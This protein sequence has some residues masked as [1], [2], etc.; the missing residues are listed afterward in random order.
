VIGKRLSKLTATCNQALSVAA[1]IGR[2]F[3][4]ETLR[5]LTDIDEDV[6]LEALE[7]AQRVRVVDDASIAGEVRFR[8]NHALFRQTLYEELFTPR[9]LRLHQRVARVLEAQYSAHLEDHAAVLSEHFAQSSDSADLDKARHYAELAAAAATRISAHGEAARHL[10]SALHLLGLLDN[11]TTQQRC[12]LLLRLGESMVA[13]GE[14]QSTVDEVA[15]EAFRL[16]EAL[17]DTA[18]A[19]SACTIGLRG[20]SSQRGFSIVDTPDFRR[21]TERPDRYAQP[22]SLE[23]VTADLARVASLWSDGQE[24]AAHEIPVR[25]VQ[26]AWRIGQVR[27][28]STLLVDVWMVSPHRQQE[29]LDLANELSPTVDESNPATRS[30]VARLHMG[31]VFL[32][33]CDR[34]KCQA[35]WG[36]LPEQVEQTR[37]PFVR[38]TDCRARLITECLDGRPASALELG[39]RI[40]N[41]NEAFGLGLF[42]QATAGMYVWR[43][44]LHLGSFDQAV[45]ALTLSVQQVAPADVGVFGFSGVLSAQLSLTLAYARR[46]AE[47]RTILQQFLD[48]RRIGQPADETCMLILVALLETAVVLED[49]SAARRLV[50][51]LN[52]AAHLVCVGNSMTVIARHL[53]AAKALMGDREQHVSSA[54]KFRACRT[55]VDANAARTQASTTLRAAHP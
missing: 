52:V 39:D 48:A 9:R 50:T 6:L 8:F 13:A 26:G 37:I 17:G 18:R 20:F 4:F 54:R 51:A 16:A 40:A 22:D 7:Q 34:Q 43:P 53:G 12:D 24:T 44:H 3:G 42:A 32:T 2:E 11:H 14:G 5:Q 19:L 49:A 27:N 47:A 30:C 55:R 21:W 38:L 36:K 35:S 15:P 33:W 25:A 28:M 45:A 23:R 31:D 1:V 10:R 46:T 29:R 41:D